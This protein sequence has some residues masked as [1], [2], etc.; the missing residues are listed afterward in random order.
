[1]SL[2]VDKQGRTVGRTL[3][4]DAGHFCWPFCY[5]QEAQVSPNPA[6]SDY[7]SDDYEF[8]ASDLELWAAMEENKSESSEDPSEENKSEVFV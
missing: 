8:D 4:Q 2:R 6:D 3:V 7:N 5:F 1:V